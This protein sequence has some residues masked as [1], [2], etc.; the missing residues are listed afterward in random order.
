MASTWVRFSRSIAAR[1]DGASTFLPSTCLVIRTPNGEF[2]AIAAASSNER[3]SSASSATTSFA[4]PIRS[5]SSAPT[6]RP[7]SI[8]SEAIPSPTMRGSM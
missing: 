1:S 7:V 8:S 5:A 2:A 6:W 3:S 4:S